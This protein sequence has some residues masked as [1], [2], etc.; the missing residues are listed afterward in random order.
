MNEIEQYEAALNEN[1]DDACRQ[2]DLALCYLRHERNRQALELLDGMLRTHKRDPRAFYARAVVY[3]SM[4]NYSKAG[5]DFLRTIALDP[6]FLDAYKHLGF[7]QLTLGKEEAARKT[8]KTALEKDPS[9]AGLYCV[10]GDVYLDTGEPEKA[11]AAFEKAFELDPQSAEPHCKLA[12]Y[13]VSK[14]DMKGLK[15][16]YDLLRDLDPSMAAQIE[17][18]FFQPL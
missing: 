2:Y 6:D 11:K 12:M 13:Y 8:L 14:G 15:K 5:C 3:L 1:P 17:T 4:N 10:L 9:D 18:L 7:I 16:E